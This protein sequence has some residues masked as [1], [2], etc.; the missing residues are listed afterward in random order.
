[1]K[2]RKFS[3]NSNKASCIGMVFKTNR[4][5]SFSSNLEPKIIDF[6]K[7]LM[8]WRHRKLTLV[9]KIVVKKIICTPKTHISFNI[10]AI[11]AKGNY[12]TYRKLMYDFIWDIFHPSRIGT[13]SYPSVLYQFRCLA[14][15]HNTVT[16]TSMSLEL[17]YLQLSHCAPH[18]HERLRQT[19]SIITLI[20]LDSH[21]RIQ[22]ISS[23]GVP[24]QSDK[25]SSDNVFLV[26][27]LFYRSQMVNFKEIYHFSRFQRGSNIFLVGGGESN[28]FQ[29]GEGVQLLIPYRN[30]NN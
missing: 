18:R 15:G 9:V 28:F 6:E 25:K 2:H 23:G 17:A 22:E 11:S 21:A 1:M 26:L 4:E 12:K 5:N 20:I 8:Q 14:L 3:W 30:Q 10:L 27:S 29:R 19:L 13:I 24:G 16:L 7:C